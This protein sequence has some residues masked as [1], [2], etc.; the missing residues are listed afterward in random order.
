MVFAP[1]ADLQI[2]SGV[3][4]KFI[5]SKCPYDGGTKEQLF[6]WRK[7]KSN[8]HVVPTI[9]PRWMKGKPWHTCSWRAQA[10]KAR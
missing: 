7:E 8:A 10:S 4:N 6:A 1:I 5:S 3:R 9:N 2:G